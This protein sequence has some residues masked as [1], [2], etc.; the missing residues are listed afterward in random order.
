MGAARSTR[1]TLLQEARASGR[2]Q[3]P[4]RGARAL[5]ILLFL[6]AMVFILVGSTTLDYPSLTHHPL[7][8]RSLNVLVAAECYLCALA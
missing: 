6:M 5:L 1:S 8:Q 3:R 2:L 7:P 4:R